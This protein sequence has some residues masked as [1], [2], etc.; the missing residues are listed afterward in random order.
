M[1]S[2]YINHLRRRNVQQLRTGNDKFLPVDR[3]MLLNLGLGKQSTSIRFR[4]ALH[5][6]V[7]ILLDISFIHRL[8]CGHFLAES[9][10]VPWH[11][12]PVAI[13]THKRNS[14]NTRSANMVSHNL[15][16]TSL[17]DV[18]HKTDYDVVKVARQVVL[19]SNTQ[20][21]VLATGNS[22][23]LLTIKR[24]AMPIDRHGTFESHGVVDTSPEKAFSIL[25]STVSEPLV[26]Q[27]KHMIIAQCGPF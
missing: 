10:V 16:Q 2:S 4:V 19:Q 3:L 24:R 5:F 9:K 7:T 27:P 23:T 11:S 25:V 12:A 8:I 20:H 1:P 26:R 14:L 18:H 22:H 15:E 17:H 21:H 6:A 13:L